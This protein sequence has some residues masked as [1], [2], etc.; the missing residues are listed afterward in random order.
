LSAS[1]FY[2]QSLLAVATAKLGAARFHQP[3]SMA[4]PEPRV[5]KKTGEGCDRPAVDQELPIDINYQK[6]SEW[7]VRCLHQAL[8]HG[9]GS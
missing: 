2:L 5:V 9:V 1:I 8:W 6:L 4:S 7:L 3:L